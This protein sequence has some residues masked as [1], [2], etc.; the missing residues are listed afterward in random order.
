MFKSKFKA[1]VSFSFW[2]VFAAPVLAQ[3]R[4]V[5]NSPIDGFV[6]EIAA[7]DDGVSGGSSIKPWLSLNLNISR[8]DDY[9]GNISPCESKPF[10]LDFSDAMYNEFAQLGS[11]EIGISDSVAAHVFSPLL[12][13][14]LKA[15]E[16]LAGIAKDRYDRTVIELQ[17]AKALREVERNHISLR[18][19][20]EK[21]YSD[22]Q[23]EI[24]K[25]TPDNQDEMT[26]TT[27]ARLQR[28]Q[29]VLRARE[30]E[31]FDARLDKFVDDDLPLL[32]GSAKADWKAA[33]C[34][35]EILEATKKLGEVHCPQACR[36][37]E[38]HALVGQ[39]VTQGDP[40]VTIMLS[41]SVPQ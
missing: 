27:A 29:D 38:V 35:V 40:L 2:L 36:I 1:Y 33:Q 10:G 25:R 28:E 7:K 17:E 24:A 37:V 5:L 9:L 14:E 15:A 23:L 30:R 39:W 26:A 12:E 34:E 13:K 16:A 31:I 18:H 41:E 8:H 3:D 22:Q 32:M 11:Y 6:I 21:S 20:V 4:F 19:D